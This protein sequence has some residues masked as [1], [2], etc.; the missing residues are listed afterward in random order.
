MAE[1]PM[2]RAQFHTMLEGTKEDW[3]RIN[4][5]MKP[6]IAELPDRVLVHLRLL[7]GDCGG[8]AV[9]RMEPACRRRRGLIRTAVMKSM[10]YAPC[11]TT[12]ATSSVRAIMPISA[13]RS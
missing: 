13:Q 2:P 11:C 1:A 9:D 3:A 12:W 10:S 7:E 4:Q 8:F 5:A 6:F